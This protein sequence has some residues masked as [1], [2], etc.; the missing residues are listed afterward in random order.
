[1]RTRILAVLVL[2]VV[3]TAAALTLTLTSDH[4]PNR[5][6]I[7]AVYLVIVWSFIATGLVAWARRPGNNFGPLM[8]AVGFGFM[9]GALAE[10]S[11][12]YVF[13]A[14]EIL[15]GLG[16]AIFV[17]ALLAFPRGY[18][19]TKLVYAIVGTAY[20]LVLGVQTLYNVFG[21]GT[22]DGCPTNALQAWDS[23]TA[24]NVVGALAVLG[25][26]FVIGGTAWVLWRRWRAAS[27]PLRRTL[28]PIFATSAATLV[29]LSLAIGISF[30][31]Q[32]A[33][34]V[35]WWFVIISFALVPLAFLAGLLQIR[36]ARASV[37]VLVVELLSA[38]GLPQLRDAIARTLNDPDLELA[39]WLPDTYEWIGSDGRPF[40]L[41][42]E[43]AEEGKATTFVE[44]EGEVVA[45]LVHDQALEE[46]RD[47]VD[48]VSA[49]ASLALA[50]QRTV[51]ALRQ[52][53]GRYRALLDAA[54]DLMFRFDRD[55][56]YLDFNG[57]PD[58]LVTPPEQL[59]GSRAHDVLPAEVADKI[60]S[61]VREAIDT[62]RLVTGDYRV[63]IEGV[64]RD[65]EARIVKDGEEAILVA[66]E[67]T[68]LKRLNAQVERERDYIRTVVDNAP[69]LFCMI[70]T[71]GRIVRFNQTLGQ[72]AG[73][74]ELP[75]IREKCFWEVFIVPEE[76]DDVRRQ[77]ESLA[78]EG[79]AGEHENRWRA[80]GGG[81]AV[82]A[83]TTT[84][85]L[86]EHGRP[87]FLIS[88]VE[89]TERKR[90]EE[91]LRRSRAR[92]VQA[93]DA[94]RR[95]LER[96]LHD[97][98]QQRLVSLSLALRLAQAKLKTDPDEASSLL[99]S[100]SEELAQALE[101]L[102]ELARGIHPAV[103]SDR[104]LSAALEALAG[105]AP[106]PVEI[107][108]PEERLPPPVEAA[109][110]YVV[111]EAL[112]NVAKY[113]QASSVD[114]RVTRLNGHAVVEV[115]DNGVGGAD[116]LQGSGLRGLA[117]RVEALDGRLHVE[118]APGRGTVV[119][120]EIPCG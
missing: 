47:L 64:E 63:E 57:H 39:L 102:R 35:I 30:V 24:R 23:Q 81:Q 29:F 96:N 91:E 67:F 65:F 12:E 31:S 84:P 36:L 92:L 33:S 9:L 54:P 90:Q 43:A 60:V 117:D 80:A 4:E 46:E 79:A 34:D 104:G 89:I 106:L 20:F 18:L 87:N 76:A 88:G 59:L 48:A 32:E 42:A 119:R 99:G 27:P 41:A 62:G 37:A 7:A 44:H 19:E 25:A 28:A 74:P 10:S 21:A 14:G 55:G 38:D 16:I 112:T 82:V 98:A 69:S 53:E 66:R 8:I 17:H 118:S 6:F 56:T 93:A 113:A 49:A 116:P 86:D 110:Y 94:E 3:A 51:E 83:W 115:A 73:V 109:A 100:A 52:S 114:V 120:A 105:R 58:D 95:R 5:A 70:D 85:L 61:G 40:D 11:N 101:E 108:A 111:S 45:T 71:Q 15:G 78:A 77:L 68:E 97:G 22:C 103:L 13:A 72:L 107:L 2:A 75:E 26:G 50:R 1:M